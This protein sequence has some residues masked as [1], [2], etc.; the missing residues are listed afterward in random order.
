LSL[1]REHQKRA[2]EKKN[3]LFIERRKIKIEVKVK[4]LPY[5]DM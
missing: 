5:H 4:V 2:G 3:T 1:K